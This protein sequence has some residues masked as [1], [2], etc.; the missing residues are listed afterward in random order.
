MVDASQRTHHG[1]IQPSA[2]RIQGYKHKSFGKKIT[3]AVDEVKR[4]DHQLTIMKKTK[5]NHG[6]MTA[7][8]G[9]VYDIPLAQ[10]QSVDGALS[11]ASTKV[12]SASV[13]FSDTTGTF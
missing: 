1:D 4:R 2:V 8:L 10:S 11:T 6:L 13:R 3:D 7:Q 9:S 12:G 5:E